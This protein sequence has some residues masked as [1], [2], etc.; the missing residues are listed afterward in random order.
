MLNLVFLENFFF[1]ANFYGYFISFR[2]IDHSF[3]ETSVWDWNPAGS[4]WIIWLKINWLLSKSDKFIVLCH[5]FAICCL[6]L[7]FSNTGVL[8]RTWIFGTVHSQSKNDIFGTNW[9]FL[10]IWVYEYLLYLM[11]FHLLDVL[12]KYRV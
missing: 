9:E 8:K 7:H 10:L 12:L 11:T 3:G 1:V 5:V 4:F 2:R 6:L